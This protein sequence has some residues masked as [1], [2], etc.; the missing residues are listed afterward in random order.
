[1]Q[2]LIHVLLGLTMTSSE[3]NIQTNVQ[4]VL[5][6]TFVPLVSN[7]N[8]Q[9]NRSQIFLVP[10]ENF[11]LR[12][13][14]ARMKMTLVFRAALLVLF[15]TK[16]ENGELKIVKN[17]LKVNFVTLVPRRLKHVPTDTTL[18][19]SELDLSPI[20]S[21]VLRVTNVTLSSEQFQF[22]NQF[23]V[24]QVFIQHRVQQI[25]TYVEKDITVI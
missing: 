3:S 7:M 16:E 6:V 1:M 15:S 5:K 23:L 20:V 14:L 13:L 9:V 11:V 4:T 12:A 18:I 19:V 8:H 24:G 10:K 25:V 2:Q 21:F 22:L 17:V